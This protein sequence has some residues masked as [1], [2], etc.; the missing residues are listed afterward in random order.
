MRVGG[1]CGVNNDMYLSLRHLLLLQD[2]YGTARTL[3]IDSIDLRR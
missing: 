1:D 2:T 3:T